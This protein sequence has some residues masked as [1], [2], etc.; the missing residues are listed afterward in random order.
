MGEE[1]LRILHKTMKKVTEDIESMSFN[2]AISALMVLSNHLLTLKE[3]VPVEAAEKLALMVSPFA[4]HL[5]EECWS[6]LGNSETLAYH[7]WIVYD[8][9]LCIDSTITMGVQVN[10]KRG[11]EIT[12]A[13]DADQETA[14][15]LAQAVES[16]QGKLDGK[17]IKKIIYVPGKILNI[18]AK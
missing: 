7:P 16:V 18:V 15:S 6:L 9:E 5:G 1:T 13:K 8:E 12:I 2:T 11:G 14:M 3:N 17:E 4:P 10:G